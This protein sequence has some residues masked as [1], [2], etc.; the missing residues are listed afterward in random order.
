MVFELQTKTEMAPLCPTAKSE[1]NILF[2]ELG[3]FFGEGGLAEILS[4]W[5]TVP[6]VKGQGRKLCFGVWES[7]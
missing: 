1:L 6:K 2:V 3:Q 5:A 7:Q 4:S